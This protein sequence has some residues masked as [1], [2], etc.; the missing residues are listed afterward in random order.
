MTQ[1]I[2]SEVARMNRKKTI[3]RTS[4]FIQW[5]TGFVGSIQVAQLEDRPQAYVDE[6]APNSNITPHFHQVDQFSVFLAGHGTLGRNPMP[7]VTL[8]YVD[9]HTAYGPIDSGPYGLS[10]FTIRVKSDP[11]GVHLHKPGY[12]DFLK[13]TKK[14]YLL[15]ENIAL[16]IDAV[17]QNR[18]EVSMEKVLGGEADSDGM[19]AFMLRMGAGMKTTGPDPVATGGQYYLVLGGSLA[20]GG[21]CYPV[22]SVV[23]NEPGDRPLEVC[24][25]PNGLEALVL[26]FSRDQ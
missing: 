3:A 5:R 9:H 14:R 19:G 26:N 11:G 6:I 1:A 8:H 12:K 22:C 17:L 18:G 4:G 10:I 2:S 21:I 25:G 24:A 23:Y 20:Y 16:S 15:S 13:P 7:P